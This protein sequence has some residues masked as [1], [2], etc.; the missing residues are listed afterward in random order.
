MRKITLT[1]LTLLFAVFSWQADAQCLTGGSFGTMNPSCANGAPDNV[2]GS[3]ANE[4]STVNVVTGNE[5]EFTLSNASYFITVANSTGT[6][7]LAW[8]TGS[9]TWTSNVTGSV[10]FY[11]HVN[12]TC[13]TTT[14]GA[15]SHTRTVRCVVPPPTAGCGDTASFCYGNNLT[16]STI[17]YVIEGD[18]PSDE[19]TIEFTSGVIENSWDFMRVYEGTD[20]TGTILLN[21]HTGPLAGVTVTGIGALAI[22][23]QSDSSVSCISTPGSIPA[24]EFNVVC[25]TPPVGNP[26]QIVCPLNI[27]VNTSDYPQA[28]CGAQVFFADAQAFDP[29]DGLIPV[30]QTMGPG[31][32]AVFPVGVTTIEFS[33]TDSD[34]NTSTCQF[35]VTVVDDIDPIAV[36]GD[37]TVELD[38][39]GTVTIFADQL[40]FGAGTPAPATPIN[41]AGNSGPT[42]AADTNLL[43]FS[44]V[45]ENFTEIDYNNPCPGITG[46][47][48][49]TALSVDLIPGETYTVNA[50]S[51]T[52]GATQYTAQTYV[53]IDFNNDGDLT[54]D[55]VVLTG[56]QAFV[57][58]GG[59]TGASPTGGNPFS[60][61]FTVPADAEPGSV[62]IRAM[63]QETATTPL[64]PCASYSWGTMIDFTANIVLGGQGSSDAC[65]P[66]TFS[67][68]PDGLVTSMVLDCSN[69]GENTITLYVTDQGGNV[70][71]CESI[72]TVEDNIA[73]VIVCNNAG[74]AAT[75]FEDF[76]AGVPAGWSAVANTGPCNWQVGQ[77]PWAAYQT[78]SQA[79]YFDDDACGI[80]AAP[81]NAT[82][83]SDVYNTAGA[84]S[85]ELSYDVAFRALGTSSFTVEVYDGANWQNVATYSTD[86]P[87]TSAGPFDL[88]AYANTDFQVRFT[89][90]DGG[91]WAWGAAFDNFLLEYETP[92]GTIP[93]Y[94]LDANGEVTVPITDL[95]S[96]VSDNCSVVVSAGGAS[97]GTP[98]V[99]STGFAGGNSN[100]GTFF[101]INAINDITINSFDIHG[102]VGAVI[103]VLVY[104]KPGTWVG[105]QT[106]Q[107]AWTLIGE[108]PG[109]VSNGTGV[110]TPL[111]LDLG[112]VINAGETGAFY[113][114]AMS[115]AGANGFQYTNGTGVGNVWAEDDNLQFL[116]GGAVGGFFTG[117]LFQPRVFNGNIHYTAGGGTTGD[118]TF[119][120]ADLG[121]VNVT[122][123]ATDAAGNTTSCIAQIE[124]IDNIPP[125]VVGEDIT[126]ELGPDGTVCIE[127]E[128]LFGIIPPDFNVITISG[129]NLSG[130][131][132][133]TDLVVDVTAD[134][135][136]SFDWSYTTNDGATW[137][138]F[139]YLIDGVFT[140]L[141]DNTGPNNQTGN[142]SV[143]LTAGQ[144]FGF[145]ARTTDNFGGP[146]TITVSNFMPGFTGQFAPENWTEVLTNSD[147]SAVFVEIGSGSSS[148]W[149]NCGITVTAIDI[150]C[151][152]CADIGNPVTVTIF[153]SDASGNIASST[154]VVTVVDLLGP[155]IVCPADMTVDTDPDSIT[156]TLPDY[157]AEGLAT[158]TDNCT[159]PVTIFGQSPA[160]GT[161]LLDG[162]HTITLF[163]EDEYGNESECTFELTVETIL[164]DDD[165][166]LADAIIMYPNPAEAYVSIRNNSQI[167]LTEA[168]IYDINGKLVSKFD[169][170]QMS[171]EHRLDVSNLASG[172][173]MVNIQSETAN[174]VKRLIK[175]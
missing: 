45:G 26:P 76:E 4:Y 138:Q 111:D 167:G 33:A 174:V 91:S 34:G 143:P 173:Y 75:V 5:Y 172:V 63:T 62:I 79:M 44:I 132:G 166:V 14:G 93:Q 55:E 116:E 56:A 158:V 151:F 160:P 32:G 21:N 149:D 104:Y 146:A 124:I 139:G 19:V 156:Y 96:S 109:T 85:L 137:D 67:F 73:P 97:G 29:E 37:I 52:C 171:N 24:A 131:E 78:G 41:C 86:T 83:F 169:L 30:T 81:S 135:T 105:F 68:D 142:A 31:S 150:S 161:L 77:L 49:Q 118:L 40:D 112:Q 42:S 152:T 57:S 3:W 23:V 157:F 121:I 27:T 122:V 82:V 64:V 145:R 60:N 115:V 163:A 164:G 114:T 35:T 100:F 13:P 127:P 90:D 51:W 108:A 153:V 22:S 107:S 141:T 20:N 74:G 8:G 168:S 170:S 103:D 95:Y 28:E 10:R 99:L 39:T 43:S 148:A 17:L 165:N 38:E 15:T 25:S 162:T 147:G 89:Y 134:V 50:T 80:G 12:N 2:T 126:V 9:V 129:D 84:T 159:D 106:D 92:A 65:G 154:A 18:D 61:S 133:W 70:V 94:F 155:E 98:D 58:G 125:V 7:A 54:S 72:V 113:V 120:C 59:P 140:Q 71:S 175:K 117:S 130:M 110:A 102:Q 46:L 11:S 69:L 101:D 66:V 53:W 144:E 16:H 123:T 119:T 88:L 6:T 36:C 136:V 87:T 48:D 47:Q 128:D 1:F